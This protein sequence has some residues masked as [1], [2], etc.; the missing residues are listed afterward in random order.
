LASRPRQNE[1]G[2]RDTE[3]LQADAHSTQR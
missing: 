2:Q 3:K 1:R